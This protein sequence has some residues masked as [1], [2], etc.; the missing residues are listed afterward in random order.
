MNICTKGNCICDA[1]E[2]EGDTHCAAYYGDVPQP[3]GPKDWR[4]YFDPKLGVIIS[5]EPH[6]MRPAVQYYYDAQRTNPVL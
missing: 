3:D 4:Y 2:W 1:A 6:E 5:V